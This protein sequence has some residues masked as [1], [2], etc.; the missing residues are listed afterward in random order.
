MI[1]SV[2]QPQTVLSLGGTS[3]IALATVRA[4]A[5]RGSLRVVLAARPGPR[6]TA[7]AAALVAEG[8]EVVELDFDAEDV[9]THAETIRQAATYGDIDVAL[10]AFGVLGDEEQSWQDHTTAMHVAR[11]NYLGAV[12][13]GV[14][15][16]PVLRKQGH[17]V[18]VALSSVAGERV[19]RS[20]FVYGSTKA[21]MDGFYVGLGE[22]LRGSGA[23][24]LVVRPGF[25]HSKMTEG[26]DPAPLS[27]T[28]EQVAAAIVTGVS[29][30]SD[31]IWVPR[32]MRAVMSGLRHVP[33]P[34]FR[35]LPL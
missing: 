16:A 27:V 31:L 30:G 25:V 20:N 29:D 28:S 23:R 9:A 14:L 10:V 24:V 12:S 8:V 11:V 6:R 17:G 4:W 1:N 21:G 18:L 19:R 3:D 5:S 22:A 33:R 13:V 15:L 32:P 26:R 2:G 34:I 35:R 7:V